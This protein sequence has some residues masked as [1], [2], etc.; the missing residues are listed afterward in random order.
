MPLVLQ[1][2][3]PAYHISSTSSRLY[4]TLSRVVYCCSVAFFLTRSRL[5]N[6][7]LLQGLRDAREWYARLYKD[8]PCYHYQLEVLCAYERA[9]DES[10]ADD[11]SPTEVVVNPQ[12]RQSGKN[13]TSARWGVRKALKYGYLAREGKLGKIRFAQSIKTAPTYRPQVA[14]SK[15]RMEAELESHPSTKGRLIKRD[16]YIF[17]I[18]GL[19][20]SQAFLSAGVTANRIGET[21][22]L[23]VEID[24]SQ[25]T[26]RFVWDHD[27]SPMR[28]STDAPAFFQGTVI[29]DQTLIASME[30]YALALQAKDGKQRVFRVPWD[31]AAEEN[32]RYGRFCLRERKRLGDDD[33][34]WLTEYCLKTIAPED[35]FLTI[36][37]F[38]RIQGQRLRTDVRSSDKVHVGAVDFCGAGEEATDTLWDQQRT[39]ARDMTV[40]GVAELDWVEDVDE[41]DGAVERS[42]VLQL[43]ALAIFPGQLPEI[44]VDEMSAFFFQ[45]WRCALVCGDRNGVGDGP[46]ATMEARWGSQFVGIHSTEDSVDRMGHRLMSAC[47]T[48]RFRLFQEER[49]S[50]ELAEA[51]KQFR[52]LRRWVRR[53]K[54]TGRTGK[55]SWGHPTHYVVHNGVLQPIH[56]DIPKMCGLL[57]EAAYRAELPARMPPPD[58]DDSGRYVPWNEAAGYDEI[59]QEAA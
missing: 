32:P 44:L 6:P 7:T 14:V 58:E 43:V 15:R 29:D 30:D 41:E 47:K 56:D 25:K 53:N 51:R 20:F 8:A 23:D 46:C 36:A 5:Q 33:P 12:S 13:T 39:K 55:M 27:I 21:A 2:A 59:Y 17:Q 10:A 35:I 22:N 19:N 57:V 28:G 49:E 16:G 52:H 1:G 34:I 9:V 42:P 38:E 37:D 31:R 54:T 48:G 50:P 26:N 3:R 18:R 11:P 45:R 24:E 40:L 4:S